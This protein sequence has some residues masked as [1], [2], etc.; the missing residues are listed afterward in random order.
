M[1]KSI[2]IDDI[3]CDLFDILDCERSWGMKFSSTD[4]GAMQSFYT[5]LSNGNKLTESQAKYIIRLL[6]KYKHILVP[7][8]DYLEL[9]EDPKWSKPFRY[10]DLTRKVWIE[11]DKHT[12]NVIL[13]FPFSVKESF[14]QVIVGQ[15][16][17]GYYNQSQHLQNSWDPDRKVRII[18]A[19]DINII[20][21]NIWLE[22]HNFEL[23][24]SYEDFCA[25][26][27]EVYNNEEEI[28]PACIIENNTVKLLNASV[29]SQEYF[30]THKI[31]SIYD[32]LLLA[33]LMGF[34][35]RGKKTTNL[36]KICGDSS[37]RFRISN[38]EDA[39]TLSE[40]IKGKKVIILDRADN[41]TTWM[42]KFYT[43]LV[44]HN[45]DTNKFVFCH[46]E[47][48]T[49]DNGFND[50]IKEC[51]F[52]G[53]TDDADYLIFLHKPKKWLFS[54]GIDVKIVFTTGLW[55]TRDSIA[56]SFLEG[57]GC[58]ISIAELSPTSSHKPSHYHMYGEYKK[59]VEL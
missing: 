54:S 37:T 32:D 47:N 12:V 31:G 5:T 2:Y 11:S 45:I 34:L 10:V 51:G 52:A 58:D 28:S 57:T 22:E 48:N 7:I 35:Y 24:S 23:D 33:K 39:F 46:R 25:S 1:F 38:L 13:K 43:F 56:K 3:F 40:S 44:E 6:T 41:Y 8:Y 16:E 30:D 42:K 21:L 4:R 29:H 14:E 55:D 15:E 53:K 20:K 49:N 17:K 19:Y 50:W 27:E 59:R 9:L 18:N 36:E 26:A